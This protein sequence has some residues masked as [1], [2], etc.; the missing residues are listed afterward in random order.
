MQTVKKWMGAMAVLWLVAITMMTI[1]GCGG[2]AQSLDQLSSARNQAVVIQ[3]DLNDQLDELALMRESIPDQSPQSDAIDALMAQ[4]NA[5]L[6]VVEAAVLHADQVFEMVNNPNDPLSIAAE[7]I[8]PWVPAPIQ[9]PLVLGAALIG[10]LIRSRSLNGNT[11]SIV[12]SINYVLKKD[13]SFRAV[14][15]ANADTIR[16]IQTPAAR[17]IVDKWSK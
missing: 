17:K 16:T 2:V 11:R 12:E 15:E 13:D 5:K 8:S 3:E 10:T 6:A 14:F 7:A 4:V 9:G 1:G